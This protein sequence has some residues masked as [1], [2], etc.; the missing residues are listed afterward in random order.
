MDKKYR[1][2]LSATLMY[3]RINSNFLTVHKIDLC[4]SLNWQ[5]SFVV[6]VRISIQARI[7]SSLF[8]REL[9]KAHVSEALFSQYN[10]NLSKLH[11]IFSQIIL[12]LIKI[13][14]AT[15]VIIM[16]NNNNFYF[17]DTRTIAR[18]DS[19]QIDKREKW[20]EKNKTDTSFVLS[21]NYS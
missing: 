5:N 9:T 11:Q 12:M 2:R 10:S 15:K 7:F 8:T 6:D 1:L 14:L 20:Q 19:S 3:V 4:S 17:L 21:E 18:L 16:L 13:V